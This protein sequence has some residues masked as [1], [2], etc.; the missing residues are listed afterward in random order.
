MVGQDREVHT[1]ETE[2]SSLFDA[3]YQGIRR[4]WQL[5]WFLSEAP[6]TVRVGEQRWL[7]NQALVQ[8]WHRK[9]ESGQGRC[10]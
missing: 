6:I 9:Q 2:A 8:E 5:W 3:A 1:F 10:S 7:V 4:W